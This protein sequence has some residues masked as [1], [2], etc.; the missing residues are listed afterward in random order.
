MA[1]AS[2]VPAR[3]EASLVVMPMMFLA[4]IAFSHY[5]ACE[6]TQQ[7]ENTQLDAA[8][9]LSQSWTKAQPE[10]QQTRFAQKTA[11][12]LLSYSLGPWLNLRC[13]P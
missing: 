2:L 13:S 11:Q 4:P 3:L 9:A 5:L 12:Q 10:M 7:V 8:A 6:H 1:T